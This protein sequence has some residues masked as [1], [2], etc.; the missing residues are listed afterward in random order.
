MIPVEPS[1][2]LARAWNAFVAGDWDAAIRETRYGTAKPRQLGA[3]IA[4]LIDCHGN[5]A[6][7]WLAVPQTLLDGRAPADL[8]RIDDPT[9]W[10]VIHRGLRR[11]TDRRARAVLSEE[12]QA[13]YPRQ[14]PRR[15]DHG[16]WKRV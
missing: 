4:A 12:T 1:D 14:I 6:V 11:E 13:L 2:S 10:S 3:M 16:A 5:R 8:L 9:T 7:A 15:D